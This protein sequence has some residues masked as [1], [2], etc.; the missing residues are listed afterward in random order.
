MTLLSGNRRE[1]Y[2]LFVV[3]FS[4]AT[5][6]IWI[7]TSTV[8]DTYAYVQRER[9]LRRLLQDIQA[10]RVHW[11]KLTTPKRLENV[12]KHLG[13][14]APEMFQVVR[15]APEKGAPDASR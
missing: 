6:V 4:L 10:D 12:A 8:R 14:R 13:L 7:R 2:F 5:G 9:E 3:V 11:L 15:Y 1:A